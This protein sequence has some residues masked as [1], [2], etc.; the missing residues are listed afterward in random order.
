MNILKW[1]EYLPE[2]LWNVMVCYAHEQNKEGADCDS[3]RDAI[4]SL[5]MDYGGHL[6]EYDLLDELSEFCWLD[7]SESYRL[8]SEEDWE[9]LEQAK[10]EKHVMNEVALGLKPFKF[11]E[12]FEGDILPK[13]DPN[14]YRLQKE[15]IEK[16][17]DYTRG[18]KKSFPDVI[19][20][21]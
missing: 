14:K 5:T 9:I 19:Q 17:W 18:S 10:Y 16:A 20:K 7:L 2:D 13:K 12:V 11:P 21:K 15:F 6:R 1:F 8:I 3:L 4:E